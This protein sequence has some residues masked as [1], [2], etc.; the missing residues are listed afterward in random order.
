MAPKFIA[1]IGRADYASDASG[2]L[3]AE[4]LAASVA[5]CGG[6][7]YDGLYF[8]HVP[9]AFEPMELAAYVAAD[10]GFASDIY[11]AQRAGLIAP[12]MC[13]RMYATLDQFLNGRLV[14]VL[15]TNTTQAAE[16]GDTQASHMI[17]RA[18]EYASVMRNLWDADGPIDHAG[19]Y[20]KF[21]KGR[22]HVSTV[23]KG[24]TPLFLSCASSDVIEKDSAFTGIVLPRGAVQPTAAAIATFKAQGFQVAVHID[25][26]VDDV[27]VAIKLFVQS[28]AQTFIVT[29][30]NGHDALTTRHPQ[31]IATCRSTA[32]V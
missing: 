15:D 14:A 21:N 10:I 4:K 28:G 5:G 31:F 25:A 8:A 29:A 32:Q 1:A 9:G 23:K 27:D 19:A 22:T 3:S 17:D 12:T 26:A 6:A 13:S 11:V 20:Y 16:D 30:P 7:G 2:A 24:Q 18:Y